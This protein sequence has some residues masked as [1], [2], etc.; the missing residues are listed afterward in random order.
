MKAVDL[1]NTVYEGKAEKGK[2]VE[3]IKE[4]LNRRFQNV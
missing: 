4:V 1:I 3:N 2:V